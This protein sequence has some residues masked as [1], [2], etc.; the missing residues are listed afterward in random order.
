MTIEIIGDFNPNQVY[1]AGSLT[2]LL[3]TYVS[4]S[5]LATRFDLNLILDDKHFFTSICTSEKS[6]NFLRHFQHLLGGEFS[7]HDICSYYAGLP[8]T[9]DPS[10]EEL[11]HVDAGHPFKHHSIM[12]EETFLFMCQNKITPVFHAASKFHYSELSIIFLGYLMELIYELRIEDLFQQYIIHAFHLKNSTFSRKRT[13]NVLIQDLSDHYDY[14]SIAILDHG[15][16][17][18]SNGFYTTLNDMKIILEN[19]LQQPIF[20]LMT[21]VKHARAAS[22][23]LMNGLTVE[24]RRVDDDIIY[25]Y[26]GLSFSGCNLWAYSTKKKKGYITFNNSEEE[27]YTI[28]YDQQLGYSE[29]ST[30]PEHTQKIYKQF[31]STY[32][33]NTLKKLIPNEYQGHYHRVRINEKNLHDIFTVGED[34]IIIRNP[35]KIKYDVIFANQAYRVQGKDHIP[36]AKVGFYQVA[37]GNR[38]MFYDGT[39]YKKLN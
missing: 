15:Y 20:H 32:N 27:I 35:D 9:F 8:Y 13:D 37:S 26:E 10:E 30:V 39:L 16:F 1:C 25:G 7:L 38:Y 11:E 24:L 23:R 12:E 22:N 18:Y 33:D 5:H 17:C 29:F 21:D 3:T 14:P 4:L 2:K 34:F 36:G 6:K 31:L 19:F 28:I